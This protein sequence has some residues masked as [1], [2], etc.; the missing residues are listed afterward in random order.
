MRILL[1]LAL[2]MLVGCREYRSTEE[3][4]FV[5]TQRD[6]PK[7]CNRS[8]GLE[9]TGKLESNPD[10]ISCICREVQ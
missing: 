4:L 9:W 1:V 10:A 6:C 5:R 7:I 3:A 8:K 2:F